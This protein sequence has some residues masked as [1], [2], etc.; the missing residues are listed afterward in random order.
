M[1]IRKQ[2]KQR[3]QRMS[4][5]LLFSGLVF[6]FLVLTVLVVALVVLLLLHLGTLRM[7]EGIL[8]MGNFL[9]VLALSSVVIGTLL[10]ATMGRIPLRSVNKL[11]NAMNRLAEGDF[12]TRLQ[13]GEPLVRFSFAQEL[14]ESFN[15]MA[16]ELES[17]ELLRSDFINNF[18]HEFK[19]PIVSIAG[20]AK[21]LRRGGLD[22]EERG[23]YLGIIENEALRLSSMATNVLNM[24]KVENQ[25]ILTDIT[26]FNLSEQI[27][28]CVLLLEN[29]WNRKNLEL[30]LAL[31]LASRIAGDTTSMP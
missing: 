26:E 30:A 31:F 22:E 5:T 17:T 20:F 21:L 18:S 25:A 19:P 13:F 1:K 16:S 24:T 6:S 4:L 9:L 14:T 29:K 15:K 10:S 12:K 27:R 7:S 11:I 23:E 8:R 2:H 3:K 28:E